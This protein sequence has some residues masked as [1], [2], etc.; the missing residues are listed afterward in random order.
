MASCRKRPWIMCGPWW[1]SSA[2][3]GSRNLSGTLIVGGGIAGLSA[4]WYLA[5]AGIESTI[6]EKQSEPG[7]VIRTERREGCI[8]EAGPDSFLAA[9]PEALDLIREAGLE[10]QVIGSNDDRRVT[11]ILK[12][13]RLVPLPDGLM[14]M[15]PTK[16]MPM[17]KTSLVGWST[18]IRM[19]FEY[20]RPPGDPQPDRSV[21]DFLL[22]H[23]GEEAVDYLAEPLLA[24]VYGGDPKQLSAPRVLTRFVE[25]E[26]KYG[27]L[28]RAVL[29][30]PRPKSGGPLF[31]TLKS[32]LGMLVE[33]L[34]PSA[35]L[36]HGTAE[37]LERN[38]ENW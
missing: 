35:D 18:K 22:D 1:N 13:G 34:A 11:Y 14:M 21:H 6:I 25:M 4:A 33:A 37:V 16:I 20:L 19:G 5:K 31:Q 17:V 8:L 24:G 2:N 38:G 27:S 29:S 32:G 9:K 3:S 10:D 7:G 36:V 23:Y 15:V 26:T 28:T 12:H 30:K